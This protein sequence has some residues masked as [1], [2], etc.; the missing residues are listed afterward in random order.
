[1]KLSLGLPV[2]QKL[3]FF[4]NFTF[5]SECFKNVLRQFEKKTTHSI[6]DVKFSTESINYHCQNQF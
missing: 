6:F 1:M 2:L 5:T 3:F 4:E